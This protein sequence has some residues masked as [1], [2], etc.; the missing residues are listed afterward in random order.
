[1]MTRLPWALACSWHGLGAAEAAGARGAEPSRPSAMSCSAALT[2]ASAVWSW[3]RSCCRSATSVALCAAQRGAL[4]RA[5][6]TLMLS[7]NAPQAPHAAPP[8]QSLP[9]RSPRR[10]RGPSPLLN[11]EAPGRCVASGPG[12]SQDTVWKWIVTVGAQC[13]GRRCPPYYGLAAPRKARTWRMMR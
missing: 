2:D 1:M 12:Q 8:T 4:Q 9:R 5:G 13:L 6:A 11:G 7:R 3:G 10:Q